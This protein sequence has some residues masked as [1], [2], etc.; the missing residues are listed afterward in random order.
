MDA[1]YELI[2]SQ[3]KH[4]FKGYQAWIIGY[5]EEYFHRIGLAP[6]EKIKMF[7]G[8]LEC[9]LRQYTIFEGDKKSFLAAGGKL[10]EHPSKDEAPRKRDDRKDRRDRKP[11]AGKDSR[12]RK[13]FDR[14]RKDSRKP[15]GKRDDDRRFSARK[16]DRAA[17]QEQTNAASLIER[18][19]NPLE[20]RRNPHALKSIIGRQPSLPATG[21]TV[22]R[23]RGWKK[24]SE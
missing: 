14:D 21:T 23:S 12:D 9:E 8:A 24:K 1:L 10:K 18:E 5:H 2:G 7:N 3:L 22:M 20:V 17:Q 6:S 4:V 16:D 11:F 19:Q 15:F 13:P